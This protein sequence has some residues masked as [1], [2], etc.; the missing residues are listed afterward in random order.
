MDKSVK[1][2]NDMWN[3]PAKER[4][5]TRISAENCDKT[6]HPYYRIVA[7]HLRENLRLLNLKMLSIFGST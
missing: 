3:M 1:G 6:L 4:I 7:K 2:E 5:Q